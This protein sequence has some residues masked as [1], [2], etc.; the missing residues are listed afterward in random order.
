MTATVIDGK[1]MAAEIRAEVV[2][3]VR[4]LVGRGVTPG[5]TA[6]LVGEV[7]ASRFYVSAKE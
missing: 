7:E 1:A 6:V 3:R 4:E 2:D 5:L